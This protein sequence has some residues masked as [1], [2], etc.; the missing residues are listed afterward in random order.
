[1]GIL[2]LLPYPRRT[3]YDIATQFKR[4]EK[5]NKGSG[6]LLRKVKS[7]PRSRR[8]KN[9]IKRAQNMILKDPGV[10]LTKLAAKLNVSSTTMRRIA[11][12]DMRYKSYTLK[13]RQMLSQD[14][15][16]KRVNR[17][18]L[19][20]SNIKHETSGFLRFFFY[21]KIFT[22]DAKINSR[23]DRWLAQDPKDVPVVSRT[24]FPA[25]IHVLGVVS[26]EGDV[27]PPNVLKRAKLS[28]KTCI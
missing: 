24:K 3:D 20:L 22:V 6:T 17:C 19:L 28:I 8:T 14:A 7:S 23:N 26:S 13:F 10:S 1:M 27:T 16:D 15:R 21:E 18:K 5:L 12:E 25:R 11:A 4:A 9:V 2:K